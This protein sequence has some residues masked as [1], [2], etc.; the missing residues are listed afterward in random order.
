MDK[1]GRLFVADTGNN[2]V[3][4]FNTPLTKQSAADLV[5]GQP[6]VSASA[7]YTFTAAPANFTANITFNGPAGSKNAVNRLGMYTPYDVAVDSADNLFV[8]D[9]QNNRVL[10][11]PEPANPANNVTP[12]E[13][14]GQPIVSGSSPHFVFTPA[15]A[16]FTDSACYSGPSETNALSLCLPIGLTVDGSGN[17]YVADNRNN[18]V[19]ELNHPLTNQRANIV[20]GQGSN[21]ALPSAF[22]ASTCFGASTAVP[23]S[24]TGL[25]NPWHAAVDSS[26]NLYVADFSNNRVLQY[27][28]PLVTPTPSPTSTRTPTPTPTHTP[29]PK[30]GS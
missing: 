3:L 7:P 25:C 10:I 6:T 27:H 21:G 14:I 4:V 24:A 29:T 12:S 26:G 5:I 17:L 23:P 22:T 9:T 1:P 28:E 13:V 30:P 19:V 16:N 20:F 11:I 2:R 18:R 8:A 15:P